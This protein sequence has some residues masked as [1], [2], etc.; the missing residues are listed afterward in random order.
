MENA[1]GVVSLVR[2]VVAEGGERAGRTAGEEDERDERAVLGF[3]ALE[4][5]CQGEDV[6]EGVEEAQ[7][8]ERVG[9]KAVHCEEDSDQLAFRTES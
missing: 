6:D 9:V 4:E 1:L 5:L 2:A 8:Q 3:E 7:V